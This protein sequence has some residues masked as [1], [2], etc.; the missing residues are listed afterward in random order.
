MK[1]VGPYFEAQ[2]HLKFMFVPVSRNWDLALFVT[3]SHTS[4]PSLSV[5]IGD[6]LFQFLF[7]VLGSLCW[8]PVKCSGPSLLSSFLQGEECFLLS[9]NIGRIQLS[10]CVQ[11]FSLGHKSWSE[12]LFLK[13]AHSR[14]LAK[15]SITVF[16][17][18]VVPIQPTSF[19]LYWYN[20]LASWVLFLE[21][22]HVILKINSGLLISQIE[23]I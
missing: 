15:T 17:R 22:E 2:N 6:G 5:H 3:S 12:E 7:L 18:T 11:A 14:S 4:P 13:A 21:R 19:V 8:Y 1:N 16:Y 23:N 20:Y 10:V 9:S